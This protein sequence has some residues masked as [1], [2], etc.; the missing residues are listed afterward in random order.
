MIPALRPAKRTCGSALAVTSARQLLL[1]ATCAIAMACEGRGANVVGPAGSDAFSRFVA[2]GTAI[3]MGTQSS[4]VL[5]DSQVRAWPALLARQA[6]ATF[7]V[8]QLRSPGCSPPLVAPLQ[9]GRLLS[10]VDATLGDSSCAGLFAG[11]VPPTNDLALSGATAWAAL[12]LTPKV[13]TA[14]PFAFGVGDRSRYPL[15]LGVSQ[16][17]VTAMRVLR[18]SFVSVELGTTEL[19]G[20]ALTGLLVPAVSYTQGTPWTYVPAPVFAT[21]YSAI[22]DSVGRSGAKAA[23]LGVPRVSKLVSMRTGGELWADRTA[24][25]SFGIEVASD[26]QG[27]A[28][29]IATAPLIPPLAAI[30]RTKGSVKALSCADVPGKTDYVLTPSDVSVLNQVVDLMNAHVHTVADLHGWAFVDVDAVMATAIAERAPYRA[31]AQLGCVSPYGQYVSLDGVNLN[32]AG[33]QLLANAVAN[34]INAKFGFAIPALAVPV[35]PASQ[36]CP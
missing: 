3:T 1:V 14:Q 19:L 9:L 8:P 4:G 35:V 13:V 15:V 16:S 31:A 2:I 23:L 24:L 33:Q 25:L 7:A 36:L 18:P 26:C 5:Y 29:L 10:G 32:V 28:N 6:G 17:Q 34:A 20:A 27:S 22:A 11:I 21:V 12:N 30:A